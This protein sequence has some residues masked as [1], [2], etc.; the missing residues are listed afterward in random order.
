MRARKSSPLS[1]RLFQAYRRNP[2]SEGQRAAVLAALQQQGGLTESNAVAVA[3]AIDA[4]MKRKVMNELP[5]VE[6]FR[7]LLKALAPKIKELRAAQEKADKDLPEES[8]AFGGGTVQ[9]LPDYAK[10]LLLDSSFEL[11]TVTGA[12]AALEYMVSVLAQEGPVKGGAS[13]QAAPT[14]R[15]PGRPPGSKNKPRANPYRKGSAMVRGYRANPYLPA[16]QDPLAIFHTR[17]LRPSKSPL[18]VLEY[19][20]A[21]RLLRA[22]T[23]GQQVPPDFDQ[24]QITRIIKTLENAAT[25]A[26]WTAPTGPMDANDYRIIHPESGSIR[27]M[28]S[29]SVLGLLTWKWDGGRFFT[30][31][32]PWYE[33]DA[34]KDPQS[35]LSF[36]P[37]GTTQTS[38]EGL[39]SIFQFAPA[40]EAR[41]YQA[42]VEERARGQYL[43][44]GIRVEVNAGKDV[45]QALI[46]AGKALNND[47]LQEFGVRLGTAWRS[48]GFI[49]GDQKVKDG[50]PTNDTTGLPAETLKDLQDYAEAHNLGTTL[51]RLKY[52]GSYDLSR[53]VDHLRGAASVLRAIQGPASVIVGLPV[54]DTDLNTTQYAYNTKESEIVI[55]LPAGCIPFRIEQGSQGLSFKF[56][57]GTDA[58]GPGG[59]TG[60]AALRRDMVTFN[61][62]FWKK[63]KENPGAQADGSILAFSGLVT[64]KSGVPGIKLLKKNSW[65]LEYRTGR[66]TSTV[67][68]SDSYE[69]D[70]KAMDKFVRGFEREPQADYRGWFTP[71]MYASYGNSRPKALQGR[72]AFFPLAMA[73]RKGVQLLGITGRRTELD[74][75][76]GTPLTL[77]LAETSPTASG[78][79]VGAGRLL[80]VKVASVQTGISVT[81]PGLAP[82]LLAGI[83]A[84]LPPPT[85]R[86]VN[87]E[88]VGGKVGESRKVRMVY[89]PLPFQQVGIAFIHAA[90][91][92]AMIGDEMGLG[93]TIQALGA[94]SIDPSP[95]T[96]QSMLPALVICP[97]SVM[98][99]WEKEVKRWLPHL[100]VGQVG[101]AAQNFDVS[102]MSW[103]MAGK[104]YN[105]HTGRYATVIVDEAH[106]GKRL[107]KSV[108]LKNRPSIK[109]AMS[110][111]SMKSSDSPYTLRT[112]GFVRIVQSCPH[113]I[114]LSGTLMENGARD[115]IN[116][117]T[118]LHALDP[119]R[120]PDRKRFVSAYFTPDGPQGSYKV[121]NVEAFRQAINQY[122]IR[123]MKST[124]AEQIGL[125]CLYSPDYGQSDVGC[126]G[127][128]EEITVRGEAPTDA[129][130]NPRRYR[131]VT[132]SR[133]VAPNALMKRVRRNSAT[134]YVRV[135]VTKKIL[136]EQV[137]FT[138]DQQDLYDE[139]KSNLPAEVARAKMNQALDLIVK[140]VVADG[141][142]DDEK[143][144][145]YIERVNNLFAETKVDEIAG[146]PLAVYH[147]LRTMVGR[148]KIP[149]AVAHITQTIL[150]EGEPMI[151][152]VEKRDV[153]DAIIEL[154]KPYGNRIKYRVVRGGVSAEDRTLIVEEFQQG[155][156]DLIIA[157]QAMREG[158]TLTRAR[159]ALFVELWWVGAWLSQAEDRIYRIGQKRDCEIRYLLAPGTIDIEMLDGI[160]RK[161]A[162]QEVVFGSDEYA[163]LAEDGEDMDDDKGLSE[164][165]KEAKARAEEEFLKDFEGDDLD[166]D[167]ADSD[168]EKA[169]KR[170]ALAAAGMALVNK[171]MAEILE[172]LMRDAEARAQIEGL[173]I[174]RAM[175]QAKIAEKGIVETSYTLTPAGFAWG[176]DFVLKKE[177][178]EALTYLGSLNGVRQ[179]LTQASREKLKDAL[180]NV[181]K[182]G[183][184]K[185][186]NYTIQAK[187]LSKDNV[188]VLEALLRI[189]NANIKQALVRERG[190]DLKPAQALSLEAL[191][192][193]SRGAAVPVAAQQLHAKLSQNAVN[194]QKT[195]PTMTQVK[196]NLDV[197]TGLGLVKKTE[198]APKL[199]ANSRS[200]AKERKLAEA[201]RARLAQG[202]R[203]NP[204]PKAQMKKDAK[205]EVAYYAAQ[206][207]RAHLLGELSEAAN[208]R[209]NLQTSVQKARG[210]KVPVSREIAALLNTGKTR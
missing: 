179:G 91:G 68:S 57:I 1:S 121:L 184:K 97:N 110:G 85:F 191:Q 134:G 8:G 140:M 124:V 62:F 170:R 108:S 24:A 196:A 20:R 168:E 46:I 117:W 138:K 147:Y 40:L 163:T 55:P 175:V 136:Y 148:L 90:Q 103:G 17:V 16:D 187:A 94:L 130:S 30:I 161:R 165:Q 41:G 169:A 13:Q 3:D 172:R 186:G 54:S 51:D 141:R 156:V 158:V 142:V 129:R 139:M 21:A 111:K 151:V 132:R 162:L 18:T 101:K 80:P 99:S 177:P 45:A 174:T 27:W 12:K 6:F 66:A 198:K 159:H 50:Q 160:R 155:K 210:L 37:P 35:Q 149:Q 112:Y 72:W 137:Q 209:A 194:D 23:Q 22:H 207:R 131:R 150:H 133:K 49:L 58:T 167:P 190:V 42:E 65:E 115:A 114:L 185:G 77:A 33:D 64:S 14:K 152:W 116:L 200:S 70:L 76:E 176:D 56:H 39:L 69:V 89:S 125:G 79:P 92:R 48:W 60:P 29:T 204:Q 74:T 189:S 202:S 118:Y 195:K 157:S 181:Q 2:L 93:K 96:G 5:S 82:D 28:R 10:P 119:A 153:G 208:A 105:A 73:I 126:A 104:H 166:E 145:E 31:T 95:T 193:I 183:Q 109:E 84:F 15:R 122:H 61:E 182:Q 78:T 53:N 113:A 143:I 164:E 26:G 173:Q 188:T 127:G 83:K 88:I 7:A 67:V 9:P 203:G 19:L 36:A 197:L 128:F 107:Y 106:Y 144:D 100:S 98:G 81:A 180:Y 178:G 171:V 86:F 192:A 44:L 43:S 38:K 123:R 4:V 154:L 205:S 59:V 135:G 47:S 25:I 32:C 201:M 63:Y 75:V 52:M 102:V 34:E 146:V 120:Y 71:A 206:Y 11:D 87:T 199:R